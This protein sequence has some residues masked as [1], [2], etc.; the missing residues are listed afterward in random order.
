[1]TINDGKSVVLFKHLQK[2]KPEFV[3]FYF[4]CADSELKSKTFINA[5]GFT[6]K[7]KN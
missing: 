3:L 4:K 6:L 7:I 1:L 2:I 5:V